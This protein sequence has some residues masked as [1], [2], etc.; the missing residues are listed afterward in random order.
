MNKIICRKCNGPHLTIKCKNNLELDKKPIQELNLSNINKKKNY[1]KNKMKINDLP[2]DI[3]ED[4]LRDLLYDWGHV[5]YISIKIYN[6]SANAIIEFSN[7]D[8]I[9]YF[10][11]AING[12]PFEKNIIHV[13]KIC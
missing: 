1:K 8:E 2:I 4:E 6:N 5:L 13:E 9:D 11:E 7:N 3:T 10:I 12:T